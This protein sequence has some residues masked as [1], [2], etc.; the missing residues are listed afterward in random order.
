MA[1]ANSDLPHNLMAFVDDPVSEQVI[2]NSI[3][4]MALAYADVVKGTVNDAVEFLKNNRTPKVLLVDISSSELP[5][6]DIGKLQEY[7]A[8]N[9]TTIVI[10]SRNDVGLFRDLMNAGVSDYLLKPLNNALV[11]KAV[12]DAMNGVQR[13][14]IEKTGKM[15]Y[16][17]SSV[18]GAGATTV[19]SNLAWII[20]NRN[21]KRTAILD[22]DFLFGTTNLM[23]DI[24]AENA[25][26]D[27]LESPDK[28]DDYFMETILKKHSQRLYYL[29]GL[30]DLVRG[31][32]VD[33]EAY[34]ALIRL[35]K[36]QFNYLLVDAQRET[37]GI[38][39]V[40]M[41]NSDSFIILVEMSVA[42]AQNT[43]RFIEFLTTDQPGKKVII[44]ANRMGLSSNGALSREAFE[45]VIDRKIDYIMP[46][47]DNLPLA[48]ANL[49]QPLASS[50]GPITDVLESVVDDILG[51]KDHKAS[52]QAVLD[53]EP[54][55][56]KAVRM[57]FEVIDKVMSFIKK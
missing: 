9:L 1:K 37:S 54:N 5:M 14:F 36:K 20:A 44:I 33:L 27:I 17:V 35:S 29:G 51:K 47:D 43:A 38:N 32:V 23:L 18:G 16:C 6:G 30:A 28:I 24:K 39:K 41:N 22:I 40:C 31:V 45:K 56:K 46:Y 11:V 25:Y 34:D 42:S 12:R 2:L 49:G 15:I 52:V 7:T 55:G 13:N 26:L 8:P 3:K 4:E 10:G 21:F 48:A 53:Q 57:A 19:S 50:N